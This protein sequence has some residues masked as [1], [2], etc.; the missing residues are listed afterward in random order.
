MNIKITLS[1]NTAFAILA[2][3][4]SEKVRTR[5]NYLTMMDRGTPYQNEYESMMYRAAEICNEFEFALSEVI[6]S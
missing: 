3:L 4:R 2:M 5:N 6:E 1:K